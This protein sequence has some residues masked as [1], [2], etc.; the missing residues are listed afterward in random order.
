MALFGRQ[1]AFGL[2]ALNLPDEFIDGLETEE[3][4][5]EALGIVVLIMNE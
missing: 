1:P 2:K 4:L 5:I 3:Q